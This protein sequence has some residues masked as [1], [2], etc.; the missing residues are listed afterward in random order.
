MKVGAAIAEI[1]KR[2]GVEHII[3][4]PVNFLT[5]FAADADIRSI[6]T[7]SERVAGHMADAVSR[8]TSGD[9]IGVY[10]MQTGP[11]VENG[12]G[13]IAQAFGDSVPLLVIPMGY[14]RH[15]A[16]VEPN[17]NSSVSLR[18][19]AK[20]VEP[21]VSGRNV[22]AVMRRAFS[23]LR[24]GRGG[25]V[26]VEVPVDVWDEE[27]P[28]PLRYTPIAR[29]RSGPDPVAITRAAELLLDAKRPVI[30]AGQGV[31]YA[32]AWPQLKR[33]AESLGAVSPAPCSASKCP[34][35]RR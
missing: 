22:E 8:L 18:S 13:A 16:W 29:V 2:E 28:E 21:V 35:E 12:L 5:E 23:R 10:F 31:H 24:S 25:P 32:K 20:S 27:V 34:P 11:G 1:L 9:R 15:E 14:H 4:Y 30:Y 26:V 7:R 33:L 6:I 19:F 3:G 17:F